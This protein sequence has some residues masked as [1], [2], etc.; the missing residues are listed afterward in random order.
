MTG[1]SGSRASQTNGCI[2][3]WLTRLLTVPDYHNLFYVI[4]INLETKFVEANNTIDKVESE[5]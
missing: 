2:L 1:F 3:D 4:K 5:S